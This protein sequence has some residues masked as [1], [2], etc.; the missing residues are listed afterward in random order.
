MSDFEFEE[1]TKEQAK[2]RIAL[3][4]P[5]GSGK[6]WTSMV[7]AA[8][9][10]QGEKFAVIDTERGS[11]SKYVGPFQFKRLNMYEYDPRDLI[12]AIAAA[13]RGGFPC[14]VIDS[15]SRFWSGKSGMLELVDNSAKRN[16]AGN[17]FGGWKDARP[18]ENDMIEAMLGYS[19]HLIVTM[20]TKTAYD[21]TKNERGQTVP[22]KIGL[23]PEQRQGIEYEFDIVGDMDVDNNLTISKTR[24]PPLT[25]RVY[26]RPG[27]EV[28]EIILAWLNDGVQGISANDFRDRALDPAA[29]FADLGALK[30]EVRKAGKSGA[31]VMDDRP[32]HGDVITLD[33]LI[34][35]RG[36][37]VKAAAEGPAAAAPPKVQ[38]VP[39]LLAA[40]TPEELGAL[41]HDW[42]AA[43]DA[44]AGPGDGE[45]LEADVDEAEKDGRLDGFRA[46]AIRKAIAA[47][48]AQVA[49]AAAA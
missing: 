7:L 27:Q 5:T 11:A 26:N 25:G 14:L 43:V 10:S 6:T 48:V 35:R 22:V 30:Q 9:F 38:G 46:G 20:R 12:K 4:G 29:S 13:D 31:M 49:P 36:N 15:L 39:S 41:G 18:I 42:A 24:C 8:F 1:A 40:L 28:A 2:A 3:A 44:I 16:Y 47:K 17:S 32:G 45:V 33:A 37:E 19:G 21:I 34:N 23:Q